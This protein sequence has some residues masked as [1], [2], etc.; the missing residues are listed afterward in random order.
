MRGNLLPCHQLKH[1]IRG[2]LNIGKSP[3]KPWGLAPTSEQLTS[4]LQHGQL[5]GRCCKCPLPLQFCPEQLN[6]L[7]TAQESAA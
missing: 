4:H 5:A 1:I 3:A 7:V 2:L 6:D